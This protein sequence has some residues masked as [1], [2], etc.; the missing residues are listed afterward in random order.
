[1]DLKITQDKA[2]ATRNS[3][4]KSTIKNY[5]NLQKP[6]KFFTLSTVNAQ[7]IKV[8][9]NIIHEMLVSD[10]IEACLITET[11]LRSVISGDTWV[12]GHHPLT[13]MNL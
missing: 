10:R 4:V 6:S 1:M 8:K 5:Q 12:Y 9:E 13:C 11:W 3:L 2:V 7:L